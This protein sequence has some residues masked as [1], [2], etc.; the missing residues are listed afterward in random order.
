VLKE[1][2]QTPE[3]A[4]LGPGPRPGIHSQPVLKKEIETALGPLALPT[5]KQ[6]LLR[7]LILLWHDHLDAAHNIAQDIDNADGAFVHGIMHRREPDYGNAKYWFRR[8]GNHPAFAEITKRV[9]A[10]NTA[11]S[12]QPLIRKIMPKSVWDAFAFI[13]ACE[14]A[15]GLAPSG[16]RNRVLREIQRLETEG[17]LDYLCGT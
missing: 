6:E 4:D 16:D 5:L 7:A 15:A 1:L 17:L 3:P 11:Q 13:D 2:L 10:S 8:V 12:D 14:E 9:M